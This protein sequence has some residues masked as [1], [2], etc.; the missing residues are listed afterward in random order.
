M[1]PRITV[2]TADLQ[3]DKLMWI[4]LGALVVAQIVAFWMLCSSQVMKAQERHESIQAQRTGL[5]DCL[6]Y[7]PGSTIMSCTTTSDAAAMPTRADR[8][9]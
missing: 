8:N 2:K 4:A 9:S 6:Q 3:R 5:A 7:M 1:L